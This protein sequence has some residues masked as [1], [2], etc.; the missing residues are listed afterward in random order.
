MPLRGRRIRSAAPVFYPYSFAWKACFLFLRRGWPRSAVIPRAAGRP[1]RQKALRQ[2]GTAH[3]HPSARRQDRPGTK[4]PHTNKN[5][6]GRPLPA[7]LMNCW[8]LCGGLL[9]QRS[10]SGKR[11]SPLQPQ[12]GWRWQLHGWPWWRTGCPRSGPTGRSA[13]PNRTQTRQRSG[14]RSAQRS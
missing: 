14:S 5:Q 10:W 13:L 7:G 6:P 1:L 2:A 3:A 8:G 9:R 4:S 12:R 11:R